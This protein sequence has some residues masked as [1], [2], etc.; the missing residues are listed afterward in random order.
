MLMGVQ[1]TQTQTGT[2]RFNKEYRDE[3]FPRDSAGLLSSL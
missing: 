3:S 2:V 1:T